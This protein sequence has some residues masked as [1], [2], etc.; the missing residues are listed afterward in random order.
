MWARPWPAAIRVSDEVLAG[1]VCRNAD[2]PESD[3]LA[4][5]WTSRAASSC[6]R[7]SGTSASARRRTSAASSD[8]ASLPSGLLALGFGSA[9]SASSHPSEVVSSSGTIPSSL[10]ALGISAARGASTSIVARPVRV[11]RKAT[12]SL[13]SSPAILDSAHS[14]EAGHCYRCLCGWTPD[15]HAPMWPRTNSFRIQAERHWCA[16]QGVAL[17]RRMPLSAF[18]NFTSRLRGMPW[19]LG[20]LP[21]LVSLLG[22]RRCGTLS[23]APCCHCVFLDLDII[24]DCRRGRQYW[25][26]RCRRFS[27]LADARA[28]R[29]M[30]GAPISGPVLRA[31]LGCS[32]SAAHARRMQ[33]WHNQ[34]RAAHLLRC[35]Q[36]SLNC[37]YRKLGRTAQSS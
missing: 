28:K 22:G 37:Y 32:R 8:R 31:W 18:R 24:E 25:C 30:A 5:A 16:C 13:D 27:V 29:C 3:T 11:G 10:Q 21:C 33:V 9:S 4:G 7:G 36:V 19:L 20:L 2:T 12:A 1:V 26:V 15:A 35:R 6:P 34:F 14:V 17:P 23:L